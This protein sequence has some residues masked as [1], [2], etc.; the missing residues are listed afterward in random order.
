M[1]KIA[2]ARKITRAKITTFT[3]SYVSHQYF[4][5][6]IILRKFKAISDDVKMFFPRY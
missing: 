4:F 2:E 5:F 6:R 1:S 3:V